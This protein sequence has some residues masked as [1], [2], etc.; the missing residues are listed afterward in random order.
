[1]AI[2]QYYRWKQRYGKINEHNGKIPRDHWLEDFE[3]EKIINFY[4]LHPFEGYRRLTFMMIDRD[5]VAVSPST[6]YRVLK[7]AGRLDRWNRRLS[8]KGTGFMQPN[9]PH[10]HWHVDIAYLNISG[11]FYY[12]CSVL[13]GFSR[14]IVHWEIRKAM[15]ELDVET[16]LQRAREKHPGVTP[17]IITDNGPQFIARDFKEF[18]R[19]AGMTHVRTSPYYPQS[20]GK[21]ERW[22]KT[23][24]T[25]AI[26]PKAPE[27]LE[28][29]RNVVGDFVY[30]YNNIRLH[31]AISYIAPADKIAG[32]ES[33]ILKN[34]DQKLENTRKKRRIR[35]Q[36]AKK[37]A[38]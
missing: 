18:I 37:F 33:E 17:R 8:K 4:D 15:T 30:H 12:L 23:L 21:I 16:I 27:T 2:G 13:D 35:R 20:N 19:I 28:E 25:T 26:R 1:M 10:E 36:S 24:K 14:Y 9:E 31:S 22:H 3:K 38:A 7:A 34:R 29:A 11:T 6:V 32:R 5:I